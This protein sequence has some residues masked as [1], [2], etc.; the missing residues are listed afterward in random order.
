MRNTSLVVVLLSLLLATP[1]AKAAE[2]QAKMRLNV[3]FIMSDQHNARALGCYG[4][5]EIRTPNLDRLAEQ[6]ALFTRAICQTGQCVPSRY[7]IWT[8][9]YARSHGTYS[10]GNM[11]NPQELTVA[12]LFKQ[13]GYVTA[14]FGKHHMVMNETTGKHG[15]DVV[16]VP[17]P[18][19]K[20]NEETVLPYERAHPGRSPVGE[21]SLPNELH[22]CGLI[23]AR[24]I[25]YIQ[26]NKDRPFVAWC[27]FHGP[28]TPI[29]PSLP[30][31][32]WYDPARL[33]L[34]PSLQQIDREMPGWETL[35]S[36]SGT[37]DAKDLHRKTLAY[38]YGYVSQIDHNIGLVLDELDRQGL[39][40]R[41]LV[42]YT[43]D[44]GEMLA[45]HGAWTKGS[46]GYE[47]TVRVPLILRIPG[48]VPTG[49]RVDEL[50]CSIDLLPTLLDA[51]NLA[52]PARVQGRSLLPLLQG[53]AGP[54]RKYGFSELGSSIDNQVITVTS[55]TWKYVRFKQAGKVV[56]EQLFD[57]VHDPWEVQNVHGDQAAQKSQDELLKALADWEASTAVAKPVTGAVRK[58]GA[59]RLRKKRPGT[60]RKRAATPDGP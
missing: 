33:T 6:G 48:V 24:T 14:T 23:A 17:A 44:H 55:A 16:E 35:L 29:C 3:V 22:D 21:S 38:Y 42:V 47:A 30:W 41:T 28:H 27:S 54:W 10:N 58:A 36:K 32:R 5:R 13:A 57:L 43:A 19:W 34:P 31:A 59:D 51:A 52:I 2:P 9:R 7:S 37:Y 18:G 26:Q 53:R 1:R 4:N 46:T 45:E 20:Y 8:G 25:E 40:D 60:V 50:A 39:T 12:E 11:Q 56:H 15:F 49:M